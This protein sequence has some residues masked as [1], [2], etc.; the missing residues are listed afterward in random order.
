M[1][2]FH[3]SSYPV[4]KVIAGRMEQ[5]SNILDQN[6][7]H[8]SDQHIV[9]IIKYKLVPTKNKYKFRDFISSVKMREPSFMER[10]TKVCTKN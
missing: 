7:T 8:G 6:C 1:N 4:N 9:I 2:H 10:H 5:A 3:N